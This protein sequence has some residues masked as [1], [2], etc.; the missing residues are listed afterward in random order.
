LLDKLKPISALE[1]KREPYNPIK[2][3]ESE[4]E[5]ASSH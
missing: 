3:D 5:K 2:D 1:K 4:E